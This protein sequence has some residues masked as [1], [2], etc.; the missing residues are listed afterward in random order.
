MR[1]DALELLD[2]DFASRLDPRLFSFLKDANSVPAFLSSV[3]LEL[4]ENQ[5]F[6]A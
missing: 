2:T 3:T 6:L 5:T 1:G 4:F